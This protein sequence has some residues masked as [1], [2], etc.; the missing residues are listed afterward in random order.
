MI[1]IL[2]FSGRDRGNCNAVCN[3]ILQSYTNKTNICA[4][5]IS[6]DI[7]P[8]N[9]CDYECLREGTSCKDFHIIESLMD[10]LIRSEMIYYVLP[11]YC[12]FP[13]AN[14]FA[15]NERTVGY[16]NKDQACLEK[17]YSIEKKFIIISNSENVCFQIAMQQQC[18]SPEV[19]YL[20]TKKYA[21][22]SISGDLMDSA[23]A[24]ADLE[25]FLGL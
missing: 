9:S 25:E 22:N 21:R 5:V 13:C 15:F 20:K 1:S 23:D 12:G 17:Y 18:A 2:N 11:N 16:F 24:R 10:Q 8:C 3:Y 4:R 7:P 19:L 6:V 14:Y